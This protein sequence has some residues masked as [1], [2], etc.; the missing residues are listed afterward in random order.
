MKVNRVTE[1]SF[2]LFDWN[3]DRLHLRQVE[4]APVSFSKFVPMLAMEDAL[5]LESGDGDLLFSSV[6]KK[7]KLKMNKHKWKKRRRAVR[8]QRDS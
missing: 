6:V 7:R 3:R 2:L 4:Y 5:E 1:S 8:Y